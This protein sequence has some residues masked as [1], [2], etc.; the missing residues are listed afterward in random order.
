MGRRRKCVLTLGTPAC[1]CQRVKPWSVNC[2]TLK[3][4]GGRRAAFWEG[5]KNNH[6]NSVVLICL[7]Q[8][9]TVSVAEY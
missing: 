4:C 2:L 7:R 5:V 1:F 6:L 3:V 8:A 9:L